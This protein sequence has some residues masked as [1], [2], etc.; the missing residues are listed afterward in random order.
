M[1]DISIDSQTF[2]SAISF[3]LGLLLMILF[4]S[5]NLLIIKVR[6][7]KIARLI[8]DLLFFVI[9]ALS[10]FFILQLYCNGQ[11]RLY[12]LAFTVCGAIFARLTVS[13]SIAKIILI[14][15][16]PVYKTVAVIK[17]FMNKIFKIIIFGVKKGIK[18]LKKCSKTAHLGKKTL[19]KS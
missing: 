9:S 3:G 18:K 8:F 4:D 15:L 11:P 10:E 2:C 14:I 17:L 16:S 1:W 19:E 6:L 5:V 12:I 7:S 13:K